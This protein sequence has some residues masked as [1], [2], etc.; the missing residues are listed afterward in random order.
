MPLVSFSPLAPRSFPAAP[1][2]HQGPSMFSIWGSLP[3]AAL[4]D[5]SCQ[6]RLPTSHPLPTLGTHLGPTCPSRSL[7]LGAG[8]HLTHL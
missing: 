8:M 7:V 6:V 5:L 1:S 3:S 4:P 2:P